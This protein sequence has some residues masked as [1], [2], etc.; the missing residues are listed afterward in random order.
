VL[1][2]AGVLVASGGG[3]GGGGSEVGPQRPTCGP[4]GR[5]I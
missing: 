3:A 4:A 1:L 2:V 5:L